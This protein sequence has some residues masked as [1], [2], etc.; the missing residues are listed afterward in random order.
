MW[1]YFSLHMQNIPYTTDAVRKYTVEAGKQGTLVKNDSVF[2]SVVPKLVLYD[3]MEDKII[4][5]E[6]AL[7]QYGSDN[8][9]VSLQSLAI[10]APSKLPTGKVILKGTYNP[11][12]GLGGEFIP[13]ISDAK[14]S[15]MVA[16]IIYAE[17]NP[18]EREN[19]RIKRFLDPLGSLDPQDRLR[20]KSMLGG[21]VYSNRVISLI[22]SLNNRCVPPTA[23]TVEFKVD[24]IRKQIPILKPGKGINVVTG[25]QGSLACKDKSVIEMNVRVGGEVYNN[26]RFILPTGT[27]TGLSKEQ[28][29]QAIEMLKS[30]FQGQI[31]EST[32][33][34]ESRREIA[35][36][37]IQIRP[38]D[39]ARIYGPQESF[40]KYIEELNKLREAQE[41]PID[42][43]QLTQGET[44]E[45]EVFAPEEEEEEELSGF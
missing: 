23:K 1:H 26:V 31:V 45:E 5:G 21:P 13:L 12:T 24:E 34:S 27:K 35:L 14:Y 38:Q 7:I 40:S 28:R 9:Y 18:S 25:K 19:P 15:E 22:L 42:I 6:E 4:T 29:D 11:Q 44:Q 2:S 30:E 43:T 39:Y 41:I 36:T 20:V 37:P 10:T 8:V 32:A 16:K 33:V 17:L 3:F